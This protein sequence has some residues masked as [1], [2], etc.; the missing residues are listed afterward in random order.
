MEEIESKWNQVEL[1]VVEEKIDENKR[2]EE[3]KSFDNKE[4]TIMKH[5]GSRRESVIVR[6]LVRHI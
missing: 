5:D 4:G 2:G 1:A 6:N 3:W